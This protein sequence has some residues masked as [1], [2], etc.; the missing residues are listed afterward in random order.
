M[1]HALEIENMVE[2]DEYDFL[3]PAVWEQWQEQAAA[4][5]N[6]MNRAGSD[7]FRAYAATN[8]QEFFAIAVENFFPNDPPSSNPTPRSRTT[9]CASY[10]GRTRRNWSELL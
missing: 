10:F 4:Y 2:N 3:L 6:R 8:D 1:A 5:R 7:F 9:R